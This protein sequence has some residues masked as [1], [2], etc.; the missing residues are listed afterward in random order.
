MAANEHVVLRAATVACLAVILVQIFLYAGAVTVNL[1]KP[2]IEP[3]EHTMIWVVK[4][5]YRQ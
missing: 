3:Y 5:S 1:S 2:D 4:K